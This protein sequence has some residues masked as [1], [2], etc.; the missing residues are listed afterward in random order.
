MCGIVGGLLKRKISA[1]AVNRALDA[2]AHRGPDDRTCHFDK[3]AFIGM[4][5]L[6]I[7]AIESGRQPI[8]NEIGTVAVVFNGEIYNYKE[9]IPELTARGHTL[10]TESDTEVLVHLYEDYGAEMVHHLRGMFAF[11][12]FDSK[13]RRM[14]L[15]RDRFGKKPL[16]YSYSKENGLLFASELKSLRALAIGIGQ[17]WE[18]RDQSVYDYLSLGVVPEPST[19]YEDVWMLPQASTLDCDSEGVAER[20]Y[21]NL[22]FQRKTEVPYDEAMERTRHIVGEAVKLRLRSDVPV[23]VFLSGGLDSTVVAYEAARSVGESLRTFTVSTVCDG[24]DE[25]TIAVET[26]QSFGVKNTVMRLSLNPVDGLHFV[27]RQYDQPFADPSAIP[28]CAVSRLASQHVKVILNGDGGDELFGG[29][30]RYAAVH[31]ARCIRRF[32]ASAVSWACKLLPGAS[33]PRRSMLGFLYRFARGLGLEPAER[34][35]AWTTDMLRE[36]DKSKFWLRGR[37]QPTEDLIRPHLLQELSPLDAQRNAELT[38][39]LASALM[40]KMDMATMSASIEARSPLLDSEVA[41]FAASLP[42]SYLFRHGR[43]KSVLRDAYADRIPENVVKGKKRGFEI[44]LEGWLQRELKPV[45]MDTLGGQFARV[46]SYVSGDLI[47]G[48]LHGEILSEANRARVIYSM[49]MLELWL[50][51]NASTGTAHAA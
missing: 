11:A 34:Y 31:S 19:I 47:E 20:R 13:K 37:M 16:Y 27:V 6:A 45:V 1:V 43:L 9:I 26:A 2:L 7:I 40:V 38:F 30:R 29:Y 8:F 21:W 41:Q 12:I 25:S 5:R 42:N 17:N 14:L 10:Q 33:V 15:G 49:L 3:N 23:G 24:F 35:L 44:P 36:K 22:D 51:D 50:R 32:P 48:M 39:S 18:I 28:S 4:R 46:R